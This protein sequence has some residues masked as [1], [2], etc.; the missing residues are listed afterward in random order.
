MMTPPAPP[1]GKTKPKKL[2]AKEKKAL[3]EEQKARVEW[4]A[5]VNA[6]ITRLSSPPRRGAA[7]AAPA[8]TADVRLAAFRPVK[9]LADA[10]K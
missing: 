6:E 5:K 3:A 7:G 9:V 8:S 4:L 2:N 1:A 10:V